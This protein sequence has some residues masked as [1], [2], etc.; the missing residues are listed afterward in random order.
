[1]ST[2][3]IPRF[4]LPGEASYQLARPLRLSA[5]RRLP[6][7]ANLP[8]TRHASNSSKPASAPKPLVLEKP[9]RF[10]PPSHSARR[11]RP[12]QYPG[13]PL[14][15]PEKE[16]QQTRKYPHMF[17][18]EGTFM[19]WFLTNRSIHLYITLGTLTTL[20]G[21]TFVNS[22]THNSPFSHLLPP[23]RDFWSHP[24]QFLGQYVEVYRLH[25]AH[26]SAETAE[27]RRRKLE[28]VRKRE[29]YRKAHGLDERQGWVVR[30]KGEGMN[31]GG[32]GEG[33]VVGEEGG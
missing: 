13:P 5:H 9:S 8:L 3:S 27:R 20:A 18:T 11:A 15:A 4:L 33:R 1:M 22:F 14:S 23:A 10:N 26:I 29:E 7:L 30:G 12:R 25:T 6:S 32:V 24:F 28:D 17:P 21:C 19:H 16:A 31:V 2:T